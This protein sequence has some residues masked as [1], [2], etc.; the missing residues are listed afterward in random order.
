MFIVHAAAPGNNWSWEF[1]VTGLEAVERA[2]RLVAD[3]A[4]RKA[5]V[6]A[7]THAETPDAA[8]ASVELGIAEHLVSKGVKPKTSTN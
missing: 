7:A 2:E 6:Y 8:R 3:G 1:F 5:D 4:A